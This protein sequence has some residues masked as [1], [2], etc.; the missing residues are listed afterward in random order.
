MLAKGIRAICKV[1]VAD[2]WRDSVQ[3]TEHKHTWGFLVVVKEPPRCLWGGIWHTSRQPAERIPHHTRQW[4]HE[5][6]VAQL[7]SLTDT[8]HAGRSYRRLTRTAMHDRHHCRMSVDIM[9][10]RKLGRPKT[11]TYFRSN[12]MSS[13]R[14]ESED[15]SWVM[16]DQLRGKAMHSVIVCERERTRHFQLSLALRNAARSLSPWTTRACAS[17]HD[18][19]TYICFYVC[20]YTFI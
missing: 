18:S 2:D 13:S 16:P 4:A 20:T 11:V 19:Y 10:H 15:H 5:A 14:D 3:R 12:S 17:A 7:S 8:M 1:L 6:E 9:S